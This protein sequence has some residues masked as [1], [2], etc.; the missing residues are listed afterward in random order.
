M[1]ILPKNEFNSFFL[2]G[3]SL[4][5]KNTSATKVSFSSTFAIFSFL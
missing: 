4:A 5:L 1:N 3:V 2:T